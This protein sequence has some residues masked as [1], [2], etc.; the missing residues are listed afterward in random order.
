M[1]ISIWLLIGSLLWW[2]F[3]D[4]PLALMFAAVFTGVWLLSISQSKGGSS[5]IEWGD[6]FDP[7][8]NV[9]RGGYS[10]S[11]CQSHGINGNDVNKW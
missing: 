5:P 7:N 6:D 8:A 2:L 1:P 9:K 11:E 4:N 10:S 3:T